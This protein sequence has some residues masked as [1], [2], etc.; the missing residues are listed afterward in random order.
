MSEKKNDENFSKE[1]IDLLVDQ[2]LKRHDAKLNADKLDEEDKESIR[3][4]VENL[5]QSVNDLQKKQ[6]EEDQ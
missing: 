3:N 5:K 4:L 1:V 2:T 6:T